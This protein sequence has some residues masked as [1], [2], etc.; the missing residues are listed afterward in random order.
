MIKVATA[1]NKHER[2][3]HPI[4]LRHPWGVFFELTLQYSNFI[5][6]VFDSDGVG[7]HIRNQNLTTS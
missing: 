7:C 4:I 2:E 6:V 5:L 1:I 3:Y